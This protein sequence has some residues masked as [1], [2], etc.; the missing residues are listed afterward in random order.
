MKVQEAP[1][2]DVQNNQTNNHNHNGEID[3]DILIANRLKLAQS[4]TSQKKKLD[5]Q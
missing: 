3:E 4:M 5:K 2:Q 1:K